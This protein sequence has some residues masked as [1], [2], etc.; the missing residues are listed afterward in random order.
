MLSGGGH[1]VRVGVEA[2]DKVAVVGCQRGGQ[3]ALGAAKVDH[4]PA[5]DAGL[6]QDLGGELASVRRCGP[7]RGKEM[8]PHAASQ[9]KSDRRNG[10]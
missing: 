6:L 2:L 7:L 5:L 10:D 1:V 4:Q 8:V 9:D 3:L